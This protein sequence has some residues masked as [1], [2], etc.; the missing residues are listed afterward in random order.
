M[1]DDRYT[2]DSQVNRHDP[3]EQYNL[4]TAIDSHADKAK[5]EI[6]KEM[7]IIYSTLAEE[8]HNPSQTGVK[9]NI[10]MLQKRIIKYTSTPL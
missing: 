2:G 9:I 10:P 8:G 6:I 5:Y 3:F 4:I 1:E 7:Q